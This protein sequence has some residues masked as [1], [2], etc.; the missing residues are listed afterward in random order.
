[1]SNIGH[2][3]EVSMRHSNT[4]WD[5]TEWGTCCTRNVLGIHCIVCKLMSCLMLGSL[6]PCGVQLM[7][8]TAQKLIHYAI[9]ASPETTIFCQLPCQYADCRLQTTY[10]RLPTYYSWFPS[11]VSLHSDCRP[12]SSPS[13]I[14]SSSGVLLL[15]G[16]KHASHFSCFL[17]IKI[18]IFLCVDVI[19]R[20]SKRE[21]SPRERE[22]VGN[23]QSTQKYNGQGPEQIRET[24][25]KKR[26]VRWRTWTGLLRHFTERR[27]GLILAVFNWTSA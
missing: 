15:P 25:C 26:Q 6:N 9:K 7:K 8:W 24:T 18:V 19:P 12:S 4:E 17:P 10:S 2:F 27:L 22:C 3:G 20:K 1:M 23:T 14:A 5:I 16:S 11:T 21:E 13:T